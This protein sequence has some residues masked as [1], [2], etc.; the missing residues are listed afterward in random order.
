MK[1]A[2]SVLML[3]TAIASVIAPA[4]MAQENPF[5]RGRYTSVTERDQPEFDPVP[6][7]AG[8]STRPPPASSPT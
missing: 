7:R 5:L 1:R 4:A 3:S 8:A 6:I 2:L